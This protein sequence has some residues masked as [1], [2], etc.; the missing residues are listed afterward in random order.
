MAEII[1]VLYDA[2]F[3]FD[4]TYILEGEKRLGLAE[5]PGLPGTTRNIVV[6]GPVTSMPLIKPNASHLT[7]YLGIVVIGRISGIIKNG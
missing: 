4:L 5:L 1:S 2:G 6:I 3:L 7:R